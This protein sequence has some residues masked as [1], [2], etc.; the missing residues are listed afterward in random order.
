MPPQLYNGYIY[1]VAHA[2]DVDCRDIIQD[3]KTSVDIDAGFEVAPGDANDIQVASAHPWGTLEVVFSDG[4]AAPTLLSM[5][6]HNYKNGK[7]VCLF[8]PRLCI[9]I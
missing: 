9:K 3:G 8:E 4:A 7:S 1:A 6:K 2:H 5:L